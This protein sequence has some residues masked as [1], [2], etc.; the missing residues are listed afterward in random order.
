M[1][2]GELGQRIK[3][4]IL[5]HKADVKHHKTTNSLVQHTD[6]ARH[7]PNWNNAEII[8]KRMN[9]NLQRVSEAAEICQN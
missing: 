3:Q 1:Y 2:Y 9:K 8:H 6:Q 7:L 4:G 5:E